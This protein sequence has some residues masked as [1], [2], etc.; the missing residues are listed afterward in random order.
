[1]QR[2]KRPASEVA[3][4]QSQ[5]EATDRPRHD[6]VLP[7]HLKLRMKGSLDLPEQVHKSHNH[8]EEGKPHQVLKLPLESARKQ[9][10]ERH[11]EME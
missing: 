1:M 7:A 4:E 11:G 9:K 3:E 10:D 6:D 8:E 2:Q 5:P